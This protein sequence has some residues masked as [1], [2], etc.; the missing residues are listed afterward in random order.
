MNVCQICNKEYVPRSDRSTKYN[1]CSTTCRVKIYNEIKIRK[2]IRN[3]DFKN[4]PIKKIQ[5]LG[6]VVEVKEK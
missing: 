3:G 2:Q 5:N 1:Y 4:L 6:F